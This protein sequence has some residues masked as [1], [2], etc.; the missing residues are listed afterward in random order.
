M[1]RAALDRA[2][3]HDLVDRWSDA[4][5]HAEWDALEALSTQDLTWE[6]LPPSPFTLQGREA[7]L[8]SAR[9]SLDTG[10]LAIQRC[11]IVDR[12]PRTGTR[13][14]TLHD[15]RTSALQRYRRCAAR[16]G[17]LLRSV[18]QDPRRVAIQSTNRQKSTR[19]DVP[20]PTRISADIAA[21]SRTSSQGQ[22]AQSLSQSMPPADPT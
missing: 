15:E 20:P 12:Y 14:G 1:T 21:P 22:D 5:N 10:C 19:E 17:K 6:R 11:G 16:R 7:V 13:D 4:V 8:V 2:A 9:Q 3:I 18:H